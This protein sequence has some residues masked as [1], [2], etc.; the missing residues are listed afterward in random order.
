MKKM[1]NAI[2]GVDPFIGPTPE[3]STRV[4]CLSVLYEAGSRL[5]IRVLMHTL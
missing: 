3:A 2:V 5:S 1:L 4:L